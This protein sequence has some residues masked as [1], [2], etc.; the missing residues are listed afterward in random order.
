MIQTL[1]CI[2]LSPLAIA[3]G[4]VAIGLMVAIPMELIKIFKKEK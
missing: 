4:C 3:A 2:I 1:V